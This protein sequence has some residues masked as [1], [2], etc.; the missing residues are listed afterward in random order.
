MPPDTADVRSLSLFAGERN[1][2]AL[3]AS[4]RL[5][6]ASLRKEVGDESPL[7]VVSDRAI[8]RPT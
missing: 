5:V 3:S 1:F 8:G 4:R 7:A 2:H 6:L